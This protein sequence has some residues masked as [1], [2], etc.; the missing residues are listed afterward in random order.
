LSDSLHP[1]VLPVQ[2]TTYFFTAVSE[3]GNVS[4]DSVIVKVDK[5]LANAGKD[6]VACNGASVS[7]GMPDS[8]DVYSWSSYPAGFV[9]STS[10]PTVKVSVNTACYLQV[11]NVAG[12][13][14]RDTVMVTVR[15]TLAQAGN[16]TSICS[17]SPVQLGALDQGDSYSWSSSPGYFSSSLQNPLDTPATT[18]G[19]FLKA[20][21]SFG[22]VALDTILVTVRPTPSKPSISA[23]ASGQLVSSAASGNQWYQEP[24]LAIP[25]A[26]LPTYQPAMDGWYTVRVNLD[27][28][29][30]A[31]ADSFYYKKAVIFPPISTDSGEY[32]RI[33]PNPTHHSITVTFNLTNISRLG[34]SVSNMN[35]RILRNGILESSGV[36]DFADL[37]NGVY[38]IRFIDENKKPI[39]TLSFIRY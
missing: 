28:C 38:L 15:Q 29:N 11:S 34:Y 37:S 2:T 13:I 21:D 26:E 20:V 3:S 30:S 18:T 14:A 25:G 12:C 16:D 9:S 22:C 35:G 19:Y 5:P 8:G 1:T 32:I 17:G 27:G 23:G 4:S 10:N 36:I 31:F 39:Q 24:W 7:I 6:Q 33:G